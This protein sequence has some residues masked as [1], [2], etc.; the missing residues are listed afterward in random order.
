MLIVH[1]TYCIFIISICLYIA[2]LTN[3]T[4]SSQA[5]IEHREN[6][7]EQYV[8]QEACVSYLYSPFL[9]HEVKYQLLLKNERNTITWHTVILPKTKQQYMKNVK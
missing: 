3:H 2:F 8:Q 5:P 7:Q 9:Q 1:S 4:N 6:W